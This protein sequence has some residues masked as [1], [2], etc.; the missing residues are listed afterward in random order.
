MRTFF[1]LY[2]IWAWPGLFFCSLP[3]PV[4][5]YNILD[6]GLSIPNFTAPSPVL[7][8]KIILNKSRI[9]KKLKKAKEDKKKAIKAQDRQGKHVPGQ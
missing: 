7:I 8:Y 3:S 5:W 9:K 6:S 4:H 2:K 1:N